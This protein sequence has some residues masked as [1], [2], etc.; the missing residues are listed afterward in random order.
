MED[1]NRYIAD[2]NWLMAQLDR[3][4]HIICC[5]VRTTEDKA[6]A[7][8]QALEFFDAIHDEYTRRFPAVSHAPEITDRP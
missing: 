8:Q 2:R 1:Q 4:A 3:L 6:R 5:D 7:H